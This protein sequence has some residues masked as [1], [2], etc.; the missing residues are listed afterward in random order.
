MKSASIGELRA[1]LDVTQQTLASLLGVSFVT[2]SRWENGHTKSE[3]GAALVELL[4]GALRAHAPSRV[5]SSRRAGNGTLLGTLRTLCE[6]ERAPS[7]RIH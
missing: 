1:S 6:L 7:R 5:V 3:L 2:V 4:A